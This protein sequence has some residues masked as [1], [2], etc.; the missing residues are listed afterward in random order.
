MAAEFIFRTLR[1]RLKPPIP[2]KWAP[3]SSLI[4]NSTPAISNLPRKEQ[5]YIEFAEQGRSTWSKLLLFIPGA[6]TFGLGTWQIIRRQEKIKMLEYRKSRLEME[7][8]KGDIVVSSNGSVDS[9]GFRRVQCR[10]VFDEKKSIYVGPRSRSISGVTENGYYVITPLV[11]VPGDPES[12][13]SPILVNRGW[14]PRSWRDKAL[15]PSQDILPPSSPLPS[16]P[17]GPRSF[18]SRFWSN[19]PESP[20]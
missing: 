13:Q 5:A 3:P 7:P 2:P 19:K 17:E 20:K 15:G 14:V 18:W 10:G 6:V 8:I 9:M 1:W 4:S 12:M 16:T 11:P